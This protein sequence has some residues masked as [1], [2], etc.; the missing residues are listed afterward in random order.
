MIETGHIILYYNHVLYKFVQLGVEE[1]TV[2]KLLEFLYVLYCVL[3]ICG[4]F[5]FHWMATIIGWFLAFFS[6]LSFHIIKKFIYETNTKKTLV[7]YL[8]KE[9]VII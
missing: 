2:E 5:S 8:L 9:M 3:R 1:V 7:L 6:L 4:N